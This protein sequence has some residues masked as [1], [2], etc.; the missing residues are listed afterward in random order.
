[1]STTLKQ[2]QCVKYVPKVRIKQ[3]RDG[4]V[5]FEVDQVNKPQDV[6]DAVRR[7]YKG[8]DR[9]MLSVLCLDNR[10]APTCFSVASVGSLNTTRTRPAD[11]LKI[12][13]L[14]NAASVIL[15]HNHP[16]GELE[17]SPEDMQFTQSMQRACK[18]VD[19]QLYDHLI[20]TDDTFTSLRGR[21]LL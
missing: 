10:N 11:I 1:M 4:R 2:V 19:L 17:P 14:S 6:Y 5:R 7:F 15:L 13:I 21:G 8:V 16:S 9:E 3:V 18:A 20:V 12:A